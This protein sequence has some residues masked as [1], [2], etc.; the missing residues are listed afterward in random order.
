M[1]PSK[2]QDSNLS[3]KNL[4]DNGKIFSTLYFFILRPNFLKIYFI[5]QLIYI[6][7][8]LKGFPLP[9]ASVLQSKL[10][11]F[12]LIKRFAKFCHK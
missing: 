6:Y 10:V 3:G 7:P 8:P 5:H 4:V 12:S 2:A 9:S 1:F 11:F